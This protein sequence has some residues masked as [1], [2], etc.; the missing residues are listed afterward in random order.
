[1]QNDLENKKQRFQFAYVSASDPW[2]GG[3][4][5][6][7]AGQSSSSTA[8]AASSGG[9]GSA[10]VTG[11]ASGCT[12]DVITDPECIRYMRC[13]QGTSVPW[14]DD[15]RRSAK[16]TPGKVAAMPTVFH[17]TSQAH[18][19]DILREGLRPGGAT[20]GRTHVH[21]SAFPPWD[22]K[23]C[24]GGMRHDNGVSALVMCST[25]AIVA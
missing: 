10:G 14:M 25:S 3:S 21:F 13:V 2:M 7:G 4:G 9:S 5:S 24:I 11:L 1:M 23:R 18:L 16:I 12:R 19:A 15:T 22:S 17:G 20:G 8:G 6:A